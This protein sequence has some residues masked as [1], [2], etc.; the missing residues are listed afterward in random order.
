MIE[1]LSPNA[2][3]AFDRLQQLLLTLRV[4]DEL[5][6]ADAAQATGLAEHMCRAML[7]GLAR[8]GLMTQVDDDRFVRCALD[9]LG[10]G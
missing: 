5:R 7:E 4:G 3:E 8:A 9:V 10:T 6:I 2:N 1:S